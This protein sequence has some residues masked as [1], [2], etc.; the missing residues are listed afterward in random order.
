MHALTWFE[1]PVED[2]ERAK[3]FYSNLFDYAM[4]EIRRDNETLGLL[5]YDGGV[6]GAIIKAK[7]YSPSRTGSLIY[8]NANGIMDSLIKNLE[9]LEAEITFEKTLISDSV[10][11]IAI[12][13]DSEG[14]RVGLRSEK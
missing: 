8:L 7:G 2:F 4:P 14:N 10:G 3:I 6:G 1:I 11:Y 13:I 9:K 12:F 5:P